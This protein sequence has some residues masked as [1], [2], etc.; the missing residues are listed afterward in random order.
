MP[1]TH[2]DPAAALI[3]VDLQHAVARLPWLTSLQSITD[4]ANRLSMAFRSLRLP[5]VNVAA[6]RVQVGRNDHG[7]TARVMGPAG[8]A[9][10]EGLLLERQDHLIVKHHWG[11]FTDSG[12]ELFLR[13]RGVTQLVI[14]GVATSLGIESTAR[15]ASELGFN[16]A[17]ATDGVTDLNQQGHDHSLQAILPRISETGSTTEILRALTRGGMTREQPA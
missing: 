14:V 7:R 12:L 11:A 17:I 1:I 15:H 8:I 16:I 5:V 2:L 4:H 6:D 9:P 13:E 3:I 10:L